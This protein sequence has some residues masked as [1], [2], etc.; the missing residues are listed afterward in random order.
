[1]VL[2]QF[3]VAM[4]ASLLDPLSWLGYLGA[5]AF[6][7]SRWLSVSCGVTWR[8]LLYLMIVLPSLLQ[9]QSSPSVRNFFAGLASAALATFIVNVIAS[10]VRKNAAQ[11]AAP[12]DSDGTPPNG[13]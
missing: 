4:A 3:L 1:M 7:K 8:L 9:A 13:G 5:G 10:A 11:P 6:I 2:L 12:A